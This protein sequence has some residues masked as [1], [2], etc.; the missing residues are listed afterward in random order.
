[1]YLDHKA[2]ELDMLL[3]G[4]K[5]MIIRGAGGR[6]M[7]HGRV[8]TGDRLFFVNNNGD[9]LIRAQAAVTDSFHSDKMDKETSEKLVKDHMTQLQ[10]TAA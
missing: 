2:R 5:R 4:T 6:K 7:P 1:M 9:G 3:A 8:Q 10:L